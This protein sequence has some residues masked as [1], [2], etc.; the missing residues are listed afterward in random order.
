MST[1]VMQSATICSQ[2]DNKLTGWVKHTVVIRMQSD[3]DFCH[4]TDRQSAVT[5]Y[6]ALADK[7]TSSDAVAR[8]M[9]VVTHQVHVSTCRSSVARHTTHGAAD[10][11][12][13]DRTASALRAA[14]HTQPSDDVSHQT[15][16]LTTYTETT[17]KISFDSTVRNCLYLFGKCNWKVHTVNVNRWSWNTVQECSSPMRCWPVGTPCDLDLW[18]VYALHDQ[19]VHQFWI[20]YQHPCLSYGRYNMITCWSCCTYRVTWSG[21]LEGIK[22]ISNTDKRST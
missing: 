15:S 6:Q 4:K 2:E 9:N 19:P 16:T 20:S 10:Y 8:A 11:S 12:T 21:R 13:C 14:S 18:P 1:V 7:L 17:I 3:C 5:E 22:H